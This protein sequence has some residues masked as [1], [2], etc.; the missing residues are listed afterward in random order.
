MTHNNDKKQKV[1]YSDV[2]RFSW[3]LWSRQKKLIPYFMFL[4]GVAAFMDT[5]FPILVG[6]MIDEIMTA[7]KTAAGYLTPVLIA[8]GLFIGIDVLYHIFRNGS[9]F[10]WNE[11]ACTNLQK[12]LNEAFYKV[13]RFSTDWHANNFAGATVRKITR[14]MWAFDMFGD[15]LFFFIFP[16]AIVMVSTIAILSWHWPIMGLVTFACVVVYIAFSVYAILKINAPLFEESAS[17]DTEV[18]ASLADAITANSA[19]KTFGTE[20]RED[21]R[22]AGVAQMWR[23]K[24][25]KSW[26]VAT[27]TDLIRRYISLGMMAVMVGMAIYLWKE[28]QATAGE[29]VYVFTSF[30]VISAYL[31][32]IGEQ[33]SNMQKAISEMEDIITFWMQDV[34][35]KDADT[36]VNF[37]AGEGE[38]IFDNVSFTYNGQNEPLYKDFTLT[39]QPGE[40]VAL[41]GHSGSGKSTFVKLLQRL[42]DIQDGEIRVDG[43]NI[44]E[45]TQDSLRQALALVPQEPILFHRSLAENIAYGKPDASMDEIISAAEQAYA[46]EFIQTLPQGYDTLVGERGVKLSGGERQRVAIARAILADAPILI[47]D[48]A[49]SSL[50][51]VSEHFIQKALQNLM[52]ERTTITIAH[53]LATIRSV[54]RILVFDNGQ[55]VEQG[56]HDDLVVKTGSHYRKLYEMQALDLIGPAP[57]KKDNAD[58]AAFKTDILGGAAE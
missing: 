50:D 46:H 19:V 21:G 7:D 22:F 36:A 9:V 16:T 42:Y 14:G 23:G 40:K 26:Q 41:V 13:Q 45:V 33:I 5:L 56:R 31:R 54:D 10:I 18:G 29:V 2:A 37:N 34:E 39:I 3:H 15:I 47:L 4:M 55:I 11:F 24:A 43:Q 1:T 12:I 57:E 49:T 52:D 44:A 25:I 32:N 17:A 38:I 27:V 58:E 20:N 28:G 48:E 6:H 35:V 30:M 8:F 51:S 53:R